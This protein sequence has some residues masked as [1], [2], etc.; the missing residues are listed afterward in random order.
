MS[1]RL[2]ALEFPCVSLAV[3]NFLFIRSGIG[4]LLVLLEVNMISHGLFS[5]LPVKLTPSPF[6]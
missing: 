5:N 4:M 3:G 6:P 2:V 1:F